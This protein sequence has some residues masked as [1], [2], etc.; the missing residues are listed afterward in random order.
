MAGES[1]H[2]SPTQAG[3]RDTLC[4]HTQ[5]VLPSVAGSLAQLV[6]TLP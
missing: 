4:L 6:S 5:R 2:G 3:E 1:L